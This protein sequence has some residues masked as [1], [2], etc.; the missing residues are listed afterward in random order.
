MD[1]DFRQ[2]DRKV[3]VAP[4]KLTGFRPRSRQSG[5]FPWVGPFG[6]EGEARRFGGHTGSLQ[7]QILFGKGG[8]SRRG[9]RAHPTVRP[10]QPSS[11]SRRRVEGLVRAWSLDTGSRYGF[12]YSIPARD[13][14]VSSGV[15]ETPQGPPHTSRA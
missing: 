12:A 14:R 6:I 15:L 11:L 1:P 13:E 9:L 3:C 4:R 8:G 7:A 2:D 5:Q 10:E